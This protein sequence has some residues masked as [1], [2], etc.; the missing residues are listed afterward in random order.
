[1][2]ADDDDAS[3]VELKDSTQ[4]VVPLLRPCLDTVGICPFRPSFHPTEYRAPCK[5]ITFVESALMLGSARP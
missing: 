3:V 1:M 4:R 5:V 2:T